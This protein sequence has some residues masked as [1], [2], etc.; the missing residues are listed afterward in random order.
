MIKIAH[1]YLNKLGIS[2]DDTC[3]FN[4]TEIDSIGRQER[5]NQQR[6]EHSFDE[7]ETWG[8]DFTFATWLYE[9]LRVYMDCADGFVNLNF[10][11]IDIPILK[12]IPKNEL[13]YSSGSIIADE[14]Y[15]TIIEN[16]TQREAILLMI[17]YLEAYLKP[18][19]KDTEEEII[20]YGKVT[21]AIKIF[22]EIFG[23]MWW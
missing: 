19:F 15:T 23:T 6:I 9:H 22:A 12:E 16:H 10:H 18:E 5:F 3:I 2:S 4:T 13:K 11:K 14:Y 20:A 21:C 8:L 1:K 17:E 7:R